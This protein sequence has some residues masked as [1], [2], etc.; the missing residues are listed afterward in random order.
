MSALGMMA[1]ES[2]SNNAHNN[3]SEPVKEL[4]PEAKEL[5]LEYAKVP[6]E[7]MLEHVHRMVKLLSIVVGPIL[8]ETARQGMGYMSL[9]LCRP[10]RLHVP[11]DTAYFRI[12]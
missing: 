11:D 1:T 5:L 6:E 12:S 2:S 4:R 9:W 8:S 7:D 3:Y 10:L